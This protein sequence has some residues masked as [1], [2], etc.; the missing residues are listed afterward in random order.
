MTLVN[1]GA[2]VRALNLLKGKIAEVL[3]VAVSNE[4]GR[5]NKMIRTVVVNNHVALMTNFCGSILRSL[6]C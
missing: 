4:L 5:I 6:C 2:S 3:D 1:E